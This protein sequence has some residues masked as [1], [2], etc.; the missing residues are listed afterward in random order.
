MR[1]G[2]TH[3]YQYYAAGKP[4]GARGDAIGYNPDSYATR[5]VPHGKVSDKQTIVSKTYEGMKSD[6]W[7]YA[8]PGVDPSVP[9]ALMVWQDGQ[10]L[11]GEFSGPRLFTVTENLISQKL[12][13]P[14]V[15][16]L[17]QPGQSTEGRA[18]RSVEYD[19]VS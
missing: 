19:T 6:Y 8:S 12:L 18:M 10:G 2:V 7:V 16:V 13:P 1:T 9:A 11:V 3:S 5:G 14:V 4:L 15:H 17:I